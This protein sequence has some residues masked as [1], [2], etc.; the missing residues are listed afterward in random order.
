LQLL[1]EEGNMARDERTRI[2][3]AQR[4]ADQYG[5]DLGAYL[6]EVIPP[7]GWDEIATKQDL[8][9][10]L[11]SLEE[12]LVLRLDAR[13]LRAENR[14]LRWTIGAVFGGLAAMGAT[15]AGVAALLR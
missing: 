9:G 6:M 5:G 10:G 12:R 11:T 15:A 2:E 8:F 1:H 7:F 4:L 3:P 14:I 13:L